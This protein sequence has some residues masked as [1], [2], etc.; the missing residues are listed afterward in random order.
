[1]RGPA[2]VIA[3][4]L[5]V[6]ATGGAAGEERV[7]DRLLQPVA[8]VRPDQGLFNEA[9]LLYSNVA[10]R[11]HGRAPLRPDVGLSRAAAGH[12]ANMVRLRTH[13]HDLPVRGQA[14]LPQRLHRQSTEFRLAAENIA[15][16]KLYRLLGRPI[17]T[18]SE[19]CRFTY[20]DTGEVVPAH[21]YASL[22]KQVVARWLKSPRHRA[23]LLSSKFR[24]VGA[25]VGVDPKGAACGDVYVVQD[26][27][28]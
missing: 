9:I 27:A 1:M 23:S 17:S 24:R 5:V 3:T 6:A 4:M 14:N 12:A 25:G 11:A 8:A 18:R 10:R 16:D 21:S 28:D 20:G 22:A 26:F 2:T 7:P 13:D 15:K 19:G